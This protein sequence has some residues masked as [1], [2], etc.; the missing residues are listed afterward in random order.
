MVLKQST[1]HMIKVNDANEVLKIWVVEVY[2]DSED[3]EVV[4]K[5]ILFTSVQT[6]SGKLP[7]IK[8][9]TLSVEGIE[10]D[11]DFTEEAVSVIVMRV[12]NIETD[13]FDFLFNNTETDQFALL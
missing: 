11:N 6:G 10:T 2:P 13:Q 1:G 7:S 8:K 12:N 9:L 4:V 5:H 3:P